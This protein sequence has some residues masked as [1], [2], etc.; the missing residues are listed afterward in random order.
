MVASPASLAL[1]D[2]REKYEAEAASPQFDRLYDSDN[3]FSHMFAV[4]HKKLNQ[5]FE[6]QR[7]G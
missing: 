4:L 2:L 7:Q 5:H 1:S 3:E 6:D